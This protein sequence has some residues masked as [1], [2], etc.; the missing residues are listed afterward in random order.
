MC[1]T[2]ISRGFRFRGLTKMLMVNVGCGD[3]HLDNYFNIDEDYSKPA[4]GHCH[5]PPLPFGASEVGE[6]WACHFIEHLTFD[7]GAAF[8]TECQRVLILG[9]CCGIVVP[10]TREI[11]T[12]WLNATPGY[13]VNDLDDVCAT[14]IY[15][16]V[17]RSLHQWAYDRQTLARAMTKAGFRDL[18]DIDRYNDP[19]LGMGAWYQFGL[20]GICAV[21]SAG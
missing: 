6:V 3:Y 1:S 13:G 15:S 12:R 7:E 2:G 20:E 10:D 21:S 11:M 14:F 19:R 16:T 18:K 8:L 5:V 17:Q 9:G 4:E